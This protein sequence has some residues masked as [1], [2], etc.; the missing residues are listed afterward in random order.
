M[1]EVLATLIVLALMLVPGLNMVVGAVAWGLAGFGVSLAIS[2][3]IP[4]MVWIGLRM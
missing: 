4:L 2:L 3:A 1:L